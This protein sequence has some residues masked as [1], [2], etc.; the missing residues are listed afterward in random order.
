M[1]VSEI[2]EFGLI[3]RLSRMA[4]KSGDKSQGAWRQLIAGIGDDATAYLNDGSIQLATVDSLVQDIHF[5]LKYTPWK[6]LGWKSL[7][8]NLSDIAAMG[9]LPRY[10]LVSLGLPGNIEVEDV[11]TLYRGMI[12]LATKFGVAI[13]GGDT[14]ASPVIFISITVLGSAG[15]EKRRILRRSAAKPG[16]EIAVTGYLGASAAGLEMLKKQRHFSTGDTAQLKKA[17]LKPYPRI[18][19]GQL[20]VKNGVKCG[21]DI[22]DGLIGDLSHICEESRVGARIDTNLV[23]TSPVVKRC[24]GK[25]SLEL[26]LTGGEDYELLFTAD[27]KVMDK[28]KKEIK[29][30]VTVIGEITTA[31]S[32]EIKLIDN[33]GKQVEIKNTGWDHFSKGLSFP[34]RRES[35]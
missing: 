3:A 19:E 20:L 9:G 13:V 1:K 27:K 8:V 14:I 32:N 35:S 30:P 10:A 5:S 25:Q 28:V 12:E 23:P 6:E 16:D 15:N 7:A 22:S 34:R 4:D 29:C 2:G 18:I 21:M 26:A 24:F 17:H 31:K 33:R 11:I